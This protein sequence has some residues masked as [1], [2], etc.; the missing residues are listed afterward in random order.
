M[1]DR[2]LARRRLGNRQ[3]DFVDRLVGARQGGAK[4]SNFANHPG[5]PQ[6]LSDG[7]QIQAAVVDRL[8]V[9]PVGVKAGLSTPQ[10][11]RA[12]GLSG[13]VFAPILGGSVIEAAPD[14]PVSVELPEGGLV[15]ET[16]IAFVTRSD[17][18]PAAC[19]ALELAC[20]SYGLDA[21]P[22][23]PDIVADLA[24]EYRFVRGSLLPA[25]R[26]PPVLSLTTGNGERQTLAVPEF[27]DLIHM[28]SDMLKYLAIWFGEDAARASGLL[29]A[30]GSV[31]VP[32]NVP[33]SE[34]FKVAMSDRVVLDLTLQ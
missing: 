28:C 34:R 18:Q 17:G 14:T 21:T 11:M 30:T 5:R 13:P 3:Q 6:D 8:G 32:I 10:A 23:A 16:E 20:P 26:E 27:T 22:A 29:L 2:D 25:D 33:A 31:H 24:A 12:H 19:L 7:Y 9:R 15:Y 4:F 1:V